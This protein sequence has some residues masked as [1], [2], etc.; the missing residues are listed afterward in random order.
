[1]AGTEDD[2][3]DSGWDDGEEEEAAPATRAVDSRRLLEQ[4]GILARPDSDAAP[5]T[6]RA[7][8]L[9][10][11]EL[12]NGMGDEPHSESPVTR[13]A[14]EGEVA[15][16]VDRSKTPTASSPLRLGGRR[17]TPVV[18][19]A[20][21]RAKRLDFVESTKTGSTPPPPANAA[22]RFPPDGS[23]G[24][25]EINRR[26]TK[27]SPAVRMPDPLAQ[28]TEAPLP[29]AMLLRERKESA[30]VV[31]LDFP[32]SFDLRF[33]ADASR[34][35]LRSESEGERTRPRGAGA[36]LDLDE[37]GV[38]SKAR[39]PSA[40]TARA[41]PAVK[42]VTKPSIGAVMAGKP[43]EDPAKKTTARSLDTSKLK[44]PTAERPT[45]PAV[46]RAA[47]PRVGA[48]KAPPQVG[49]ATRPDTPRARPDAGKVTRPEMP[50]STA[51]EVKPAESAPSP[52]DASPVT[53]AVAADFA[54]VEL[55]I[56]GLD[57][58]PPAASESF[59]GAVEIHGEAVQLS[60]EE[61][62]LLLAEEEGASF[63]VDL[64]VPVETE[65]PELEP[66]R[67]R[68]EKGDYAGAL[69]RAESLLEARPD[70]VAAERYAESARDML[71]QMYLE[72]LG[73]GGTVLRMVMRHDEIQGLSLDHRSGFLISFIDGACTV[74]EILD[75]SGM[76]TLEALRLLYEM[77]EQGVIA[78]DSMARQ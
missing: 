13:R 11:V 70:F 42:R 27:I 20:A 12:L 18:T 29:E 40:P 35:D 76:A 67:V 60:E 71:S 32:D 23:R 65:D 14:G 8:E 69:L 46:P 1:M 33:D 57:S 4:A 15:R 26:P 21:S 49:K 28:T 19:D 51:S 7:T 74:D 24:L 62:A 61:E 52:D 72:K 22:L 41:I 10:S 34:A 31:E 55:S 73:S 36:A 38:Q 43:A 66:V 16:F 6:P 75:M 45:S 9:P 56:D 2:D 30:P 44:S 64:D 78:V 59:D 58:V 5:V 50:R 47:V 53:D 25:R 3:I 48:S 37:P 68:F 17:H 39:E 63:D 54:G 77:R